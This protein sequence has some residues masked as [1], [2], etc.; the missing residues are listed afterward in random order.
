MARKKKIEFKPIV[1]T[2]INRTCDLMIAAGFIIMAITMYNLV[3]TIM[4]Y[5]MKK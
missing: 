5:G 4:Q 1:E 3:N 2:L